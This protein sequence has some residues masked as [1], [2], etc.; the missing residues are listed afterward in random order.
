MRETLAIG[1]FA[2]RAGVE[3][4]T[5]RA[6]ERRYGFPAP[7]RSS[8]GHRRFDARDLERVTWVAA[9]VAEGT[10]ISDAIAGLGAVQTLDLHDQPLMLA[11]LALDERAALANVD[12]LLRALPLETA[13]EAGIFPVLREIG[14]LWAVGKVPVLAE[15]LVSEAITQ[16]LTAR[17]SAAL[18]NEGPRALIYCPSGEQ[19]GVGAVALALFLSLDGWAV[20]YLG[21]DFPTLEAARLAHSMRPRVVISSCTLTESLTETIEGLSAFPAETTLVLAG[22][23]VA[24]HHPPSIT[25]WGPTFRDARAAAFELARGAP[26]VGLDVAS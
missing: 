11:A 25:A 1:P 2:E 18:R 20:T 21:S 10:R 12:R 9:R 24:G 17:L 6:W 7:V 23:A 16:R 3:L 5:L 8:G 14:D 26:E 22:P 4:A 13:L 19:H 15:R